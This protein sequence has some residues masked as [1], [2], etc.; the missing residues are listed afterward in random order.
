MNDYRVKIT[1]R[2]ER[3]L[4]A[5]EEAGYPSARHALLLMVIKIM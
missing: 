2:N 1:I 4:S 3:L 5:I